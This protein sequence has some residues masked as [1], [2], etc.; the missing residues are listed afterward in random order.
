MATSRSARGQMMLEM[1]V[2]RVI[3]R[4]AVP[5]IISMLIT[6]I[7]NMADT[8]FV[9]RISTSASGAVG[10]IF[11]AMSMI[12]ALA[13]TFGMGSGANMSRALGAGNEKEARVFVAMGFFTA[14]GAGLVVCLVGNL[15]TGPLVRLLGA[16]ETIAPHAQ[17][18]A[19]YIFYAAPFMMSSLAMNNL[20]RFQGLALYGMIGMGTGGIINIALDPLFIF[21]LD[22]GT[23]GAAIATAI[24][25]FI[26]FSLLLFMTNHKSDALSIRLSDFRPTAALY[27]RMLSNGLPSMGRQ[28]IASIAS[29]VLNRV[30]GSWGDAA[31]AAMSIV[32]RCT[33]FMNSAVIGFGQGFQP[34]CAY[35]YGAGKYRR[36]REALNFCIRVSTIF[37]AAVAIVFFLSARPVVSFFRDDPQVIDIGTV[38]LRCQLI[39]LPL[40]GLIT[41]CNMFTQSIGLGLRATLIASARQGIFLIPSLL[42]LPRLLGLTGLELAQP[43]ADLLTF[44]L[45]VWMTR[46]VSRELAGKPDRGSEKDHA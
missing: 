12:Q 27:R 20:L 22:L 19:T 5:T 25:Q 45:A 17:A 34:V 18:Y 16:T 33:M 6:S 38:A 13:F 14:F 35:C 40:W 42:I 31:I 1:P 2:S 30:A 46:S 44:L 4:L 32:G 28:G 9:G 11:S 39:T 26:S 29:V 24:S 23:A 37:L 7:Y 21:V 3:P 41:M 43:S 8:F 36:V 10:I 15:F